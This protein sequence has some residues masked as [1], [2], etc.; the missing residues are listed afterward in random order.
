MF[1]P[2]PSY[3]FCMWKLL[4]LRTHNF[5]P[6]R[7]LRKPPNEILSFTRSSSLDRRS[8]FNLGE[9]KK[10]L[11]KGQDSSPFCAR[12]LLFCLSLLQYPVAQLSSCLS[13]PSGWAN[14]HQPLSSLKSFFWSLSL[15][16]QWDVQAGCKFRLRS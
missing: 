2:V 16:E 13:L 7:P 8:K 6:V 12:I 5:F 9:G 15:N 1:L 4:T 10:T 14:M 11:G 3:C